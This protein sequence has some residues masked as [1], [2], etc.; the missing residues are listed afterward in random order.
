MQLAYDHVERMLDTHHVESFEDQVLSRH[1][2]K[3]D[4]RRINIDWKVGR[5]VGS[6]GLIRDLDW[7]KKAGYRCIDANI[8]ALRLVRGPTTAEEELRY[9]LESR[10]FLN[11]DFNID[12]V[13]MGF[14]CRT[15][16]ELSKYE[17][18]TLEWLKIID[19]YSIV[20]DQDGATM[21]IKSYSKSFT[22]KY[23]DGTCSL[24]Q[25]TK[26]GPKSPLD[27]TN[28]RIQGDGPNIK[29]I[30]ADCSEC[31]GTKVYQPLIGPPE[32]CQACSVVA[33]KDAVKGFAEAVAA[34]FSESLFIKLGACKIKP[35]KTPNCQWQ[36]FHVD[37]SC[38]IGATDSDPIARQAADMMLRKLTSSFTQQLAFK[39]V[40]NSS[41]PLA[42]N[43]QVHMRS[44][45]AGVSSLVSI[46]EI[47]L[48]L[49]FQFQVRVSP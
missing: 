29:G 21:R 38:A 44:N 2:P 31:K 30:Q 15:K 9:K 1:T 28:I 17:K 45:F 49:Q 3:V 47:G 40:Y 16:D 11:F 20:Y 39:D 12:T 34:M 13:K 19:D 48:A 18:D 24:E 43:N 32:P 5:W 41:L 42:L 36:P 23:K 6:A 35:I 10:S 26:P 46:K 4:H 27:F 22:E 33:P 8:N 37:V 7:Y 25:Y 14:T